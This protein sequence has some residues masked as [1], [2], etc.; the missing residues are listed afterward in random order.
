MVC[1]Y[2]ASTTTHMDA[3]SS[4]PRLTYRL[5]GANPLK[6]AAYAVLGVAL[7][8]LAFFFIT[9]A[10]VAGALLALVIAVRWW[11]MMRRLRAARRR[12]GPLEGEYTVIEGSKEPPR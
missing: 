3:R 6:R 10:L 7:A 11:W 12:A 5:G 2:S 8:A 1:I 9:I 4:T